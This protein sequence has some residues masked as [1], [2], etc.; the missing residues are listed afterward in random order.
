MTITVV[1]DN[2]PY[3]QGLETGWG[4]SCLITGIEKTIL[5]DTG[6]GHSLLNN[7]EKLAIKPDSIN[8]VVLSH[9]HPDHTGG[10]NSFLEKNS[11]VTVY[12]PASFPKKFKDNVQS[13][14]AKI[15]DVEQ[16]LKI[17]EDVYST[18]LLGKLIREQT[19]IIRTEG[20]LVVIIGCAHP[21]IIKIVNAAKE[22]LKDDIL[23]VM[24]GFHLELA[25]KGKIGKIISTFKQLNVRYAGPCHGSGDK[26][27][28]LFEKHFGKNYINIGAGKA[29]TMADLQ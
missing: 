28:S 9:I 15:V 27:I 11:D 12:L 7:M 4:F 10:L 1:Y 18:G 29:I 20:G 21:G 24:G 23:L 8:T 25:T 6:P 26:A 5:F 16:S 13:Y 22:L 2:N 19:L 14:G 17:C 3:K